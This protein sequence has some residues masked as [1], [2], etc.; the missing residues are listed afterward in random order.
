MK[1]C[2]LVN[3]STEGVIVEGLPSKSNERANVWNPGS[4]SMGA[5]QLELSCSG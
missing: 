5:P 4:R 3:V 2:S 1:K